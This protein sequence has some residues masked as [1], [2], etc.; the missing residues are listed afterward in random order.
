MR[1][2][3]ALSRSYPAFH[4]VLLIN[5]DFFACSSSASFL[6]YVLWIRKRS[7]VKRYKGSLSSGFFTLI[8]PRR[9]VD[10]QVSASLRRTLDYLH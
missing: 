5:L 10:H 8:T 9:S 7:F 6:L 4:G 2:A 1:R 3:A